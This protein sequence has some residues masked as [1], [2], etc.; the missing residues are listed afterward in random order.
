MLQDYSIRLL[1]VVLSHMIADGSFLVFLCALMQVSAC[2]A[3]ITCIA[4][5][6]LKVIDNALLVNY[7]GILFHHFDNIFD[8]PAG[9]DGTNFGTLNL[10]AKMTGLSSH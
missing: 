3:N 1:S 7:W 9:T 8:L 4:Q 6:T 10:M 5:V 2:V